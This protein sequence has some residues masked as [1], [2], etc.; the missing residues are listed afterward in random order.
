VDSA[1][2]LDKDR[3]GDGDCDPDYVHGV[4]LLHLV[5]VPSA[6]VNP[7]TKVKTKKKSLP[8]TAPS[9]YAVPSTGDRGFPRRSASV[10]LPTLELRDLG[11]SRSHARDK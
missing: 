5:E 11:R 9:E 1:P 6:L 10:D 3:H 2:L 7:R 4:P 8:S